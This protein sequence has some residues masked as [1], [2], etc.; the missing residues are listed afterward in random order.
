MAPSSQ[1]LE[2]PGKP[3]RFNLTVR[4]AAMIALMFNLFMVAVA[5]LSIVLTIP[6]RTQAHGEQIR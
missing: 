3:G 2:P 4:V 5:I 1:G 6:R